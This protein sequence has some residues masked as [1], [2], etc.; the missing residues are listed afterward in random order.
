MSHSLL[1]FFCVSE[2]TLPGNVTRSFNWFTNVSN[3]SDTGKAGI[4]I[5]YQTNGSSVLFCPLLAVLIKNTCYLFVIYSRRNNRCTFNTVC[6]ENNATILKMPWVDYFD[7]QLVNYVSSLINVTYMSLYLKE[8]IQEYLKDGLYTYATRGDDFFSMT[9]YANPLIF[10]KKTK[11]LLR[12]YER[13]YGHPLFVHYDDKSL[14]YLPHFVSLQ[15]KTYFLNVSFL[16][17]PL[18]I[19]SLDYC[20]LLVPD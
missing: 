2:D 6:K 16:I 11:M 4:T 7:S 12:N 14:A 10:E 17:I 8:A 1:R 3:Q 19:Y 15:F 18:T 20:L 9:Y 13:E 5:K